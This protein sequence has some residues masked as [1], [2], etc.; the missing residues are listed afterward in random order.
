M[1]RG[2]VLS[3]RSCCWSGWRAGASCQTCLAAWGESCNNSS[4]HRVAA[5]RGSLGRKEVQEAPV[6][7]THSWDSRTTI[8]I[9]FSEQTINI[10]VVIEP[11]TRLER[12]Y[13]CSFCCMIRGAKDE[14]LRCIYGIVY[15][16]LERQWAGEKMYGRS[17]RKPRACIDFYYF[18]YLDI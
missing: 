7:Y 1:G 10:D 13:T 5:C 17:Y 11:S 12:F 2:P 18:T 8:S 4:V 15:C 14:M 16:F 6:V 9:L 3:P